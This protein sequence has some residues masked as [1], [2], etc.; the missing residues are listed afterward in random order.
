MAPNSKNGSKAGVA[1]PRAPLSPFE[2]RRA[3]FGKTLPQIGRTVRKFVDENLLKTR[4][5]RGGVR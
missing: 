2:Q 4:V 5:H 3:D 1:T